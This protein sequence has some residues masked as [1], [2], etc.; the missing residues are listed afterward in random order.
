MPMIRC[1]TFI[2]LLVLVMG[3]LRAAD[4]DATKKALALAKAM[5]TGSVS[6]KLRCAGELAKMGETARP[7]AKSLANL[8]CDPNP[9]I[10][11]PAWD[12]LEKVWPELT[13]LGLTLCRDAADN[14]SG[15]DKREKACKDIAALGENA[16]AGVPFLL[17]HLR[18]RI[19]VEESSSPVNSV[20]SANCEALKKLAPTDPTFLKTLSLASQPVNQKP[21][22]R[23]L[24]ITT[25]GDLAETNTKLRK[26]AMLI[27]KG[28]MLV[29]PNTPLGRNLSKEQTT[30][31]RTAAIIGL[32]K[33]GKD[34]KGELPNLKKVKFGDESEQVRQAAGDAITRIESDSGK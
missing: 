6:E 25:L 29:L 33:C 27:F 2:T 31:I 8:C 22:N 28:N 5:E 21:R 32:G 17:Y 9:K 1:I 30:E 18:T 14:F 13:K 7:A 34:A 23:V 11:L 26:D 20:L 24:A 4:D 19:G 16:E 12:A 3:S 10:N 15:G